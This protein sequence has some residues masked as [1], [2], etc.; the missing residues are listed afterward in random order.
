MHI[1]NKEQDRYGRQYVIPDGRIDILA[2]DDDNNFYVIELKKDSGYDDPYDQ[3]VEYMDW[4]KKNKATGKQKV[5][6]IIC[7]NNPKSDL[8]EKVKSNSMISLFQYEVRFSK[9]D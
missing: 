6:G 2:V 4:I 1:Y 9:L 3:L 8:I 5:Y 7:L